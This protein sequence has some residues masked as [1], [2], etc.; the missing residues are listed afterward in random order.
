MFRPTSAWTWTDFSPSALRRTTASTSVRRAVGLR[1][2][3]T[4]PDLDVVVW[5]NSVL[6]SGISLIMLP[7]TVVERV[8]LGRRNL[9]P[10]KDRSLDVDRS[11]PERTVTPFVVDVTSTPAD[12]RLARVYDP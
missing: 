9:W 6:P 7:T 1:K 11:A 12:W 4:R 8:R 2:G 10:K 3:M 5:R